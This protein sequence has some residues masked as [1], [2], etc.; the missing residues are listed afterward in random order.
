MGFEIRECALRDVMSHPR[1]KGRTRAT[2]KVTLRETHLGIV[3]DH[4]LTLKVWANTNKDMNADEVKSALLTKA[5]SIL[6]RTIAVADLP[7][8]LAAE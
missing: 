7:D 5:A 4:N 2:V 1:L 3:S 6:S 8:R